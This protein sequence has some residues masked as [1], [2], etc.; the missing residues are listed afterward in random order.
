MKNGVKKASENLVARGSAKTPRDLPKNTLPD[1]PGRGRG[2]GGLVV[3]I[4]VLPGHA[5]EAIESL[6]WIASELSSEV[7]MAL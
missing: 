1:T 3:R 5:D 4:L 6:A 2:T 7:P